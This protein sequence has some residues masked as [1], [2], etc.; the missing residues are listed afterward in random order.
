MYCTNNERK[1]FELVYK[2]NDGS[3]KTTNKLKVKLYFFATTEDISPEAYDI[4]AS[5]QGTF[6]DL[7][8]PIPPLSV[9]LAAARPRPPCIF[10]VGR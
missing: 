5:R 3:G 2:L 10:I 7:N 9:Q 1:E 6:L 8:T 4:M